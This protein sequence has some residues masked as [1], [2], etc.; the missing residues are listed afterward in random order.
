MIKFQISSN[1][2]E[3]VK[4]LEN[5]RDYKLGKKKVERSEKMYKQKTKKN[6]K[7]R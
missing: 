1:L 5:Y 3:V 2:K 7:K 4:S 6:V